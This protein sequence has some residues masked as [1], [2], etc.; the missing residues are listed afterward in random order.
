MLF[1][2]MR[3]GKRV[4]SLLRRLARYLSR[5]A[6]IAGLLLCCLWVTSYLVRS[7][8]TGLRVPDANDGRAGAGAA[9][10]SEPLVS[11]TTTTTGDTARR[12]VADDAVTFALVVI[13]H[14]SVPFFLNWVCH[15]RCVLQS[16]FLAGTV[17]LPVTVRARATDGKVL[18]WLRQRSL[19][20]PWLRIRAARAPL[21]RAVASYQA[22]KASNSLFYEIERQKFSAVHA[23]FA[24]KTHLPSRFYLLV[25]DVD[26]VF[27]H[28]P[29]RAILRYGDADLYMQCDGCN[30]ELYGAQQVQ[31]PYEYNTGFMLFAVDQRTR[32][33]RLRFQA[34]RQLI[35]EVVHESIK[36]ERARQL[37]PERKSVHDQFIFNK[38]LKKW[39][40]NHMVQLRSPYENMTSIAGIEYVRPRIMYLPYE[41]FPNGCVLFG[42]RHREPSPAVRALL[43]RGLVVAV[44]AN[45][46][47]GASEKWRALRSVNLTIASTQEESLNA[48]L[49]PPCDEIQA[50]ASTGHM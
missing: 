12:Q 2:H 36:T 9:A 33:G 32:S 35:A 38:V 25:C 42:Y 46:R 28:E 7:P 8:S 24:R 26:V 16:Q 45:Y 43:E 49:C 14:G 5:G 10:L 6:A 44:H 22:M 41:V 19:D 17:R 20:T 40:H 15:Y 30:T 29:V 3:G 39:T 47:N 4:E 21:A 23:M 34:I 37:Q 11:T 31:C 48:Q 13:N 50:T 27:L 1:Q 18:D